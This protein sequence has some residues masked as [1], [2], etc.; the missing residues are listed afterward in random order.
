MEE[1]FNQ[2]EGKITNKVAWDALKAASQEPSKD[3]ITSNTQWSIL[4]NNTDLTAEIVIRRDWNT[5]TSYDLNLNEI[6][7]GES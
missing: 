7:G 1:I 4:Y 5:V 2:N 6:N 3:D